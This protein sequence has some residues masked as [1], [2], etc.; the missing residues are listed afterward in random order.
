[1]YTSI[2]ISAHIKRSSNSKMLVSSFISKGSRNL[3]IC[4]KKASVSNSTY[5]KVSDVFLGS[6]ALCVLFWRH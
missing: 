4:K 2:S 1:M 3:H 6:S 5:F